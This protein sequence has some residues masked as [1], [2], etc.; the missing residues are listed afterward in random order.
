MTGTLIGLIDR[1]S[2]GL[3]ILLTL[4]IAVSQIYLFQDVSIFYAIFLLG[5]TI[6]SALEFVKKALERN[7]E[8]QSFWRPVRITL[9]LIILVLSILTTVYIVFNA[10]RLQASQPFI[11]DLEVV[12]GWLLIAVILVLVTVH[13]GM[14]FGG[15]ISLGIA[16]FVWGHLIPIDLL[17]HP[18]YDMQFIMSYLGMNAT[19][20]FF[21]FIGLM[22]SIHFLILFATVLFIAGVLSLFLELGKAAGRHVQGGAALP[23]IVGSTAVGSVMGQAVSNVAL[24]GQV[25]IPMMMKYGYKGSTA[26]AIES[27]ASTAGQLL[28][29]I[30]GLAAFMIASMLNLN[31]IDVALNAVY[32]A[33]LYVS[34]ITI[35]VLLVSRAQGIGILHEAVDWRLI[36]RILPT[37]VIPFAVVLALM[38]NYF[39][40]SFAGLIGIPL[41][42]ILAFLQ[43]SGL[44]PGFKKMSAELKEGLRLVTM[45]GLL[46]IA[47]GPF[48]QVIGI[49]QMASRLGTYFVIILPNNLP[50]LLALTMAI[51]LFAGMGLPTP[52]AYLLVALTVAPFLQELGLP[53]LSAHFFVFY[54][55]IFST[56]S[57]PVALACLTAC[58]ISKDTFFRTCVESMKIAGATFFIPFSFSFNPSL[59]EFPNISLKGLYFLVITLLVQ[60]LVT[61]GLIGFIRRPLTYSERGVAFMAAAA[62][63]IYL[64]YHAYAFLILFFALPLGACLWQFIKDGRGSNAG[65]EKV[66]V[67]IEVK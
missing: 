14:L 15:I 54:F 52:V 25:T 46:G 50:L 4:Y 27:V 19:D 53:A 2:F 41:V 33:V 17:A 64:F 43:G 6:I 51:C 3:M 13:W 5:T 45:L 7:K 56:I 29:P 61:I 21:S 9:S 60:V 40:P 30:L 23:A 66:A 37:F 38:L 10:G 42:L 67:N 35:A 8:I 47:I 44:R 31:Y 34:T 18:D 59:F 1:V 12:I 65:I 57:P 62:G 28:P 49:T 55:A 11:S 48:A 24:T 63:A 36:L 32:P 22:T 26:G 20:G 16:Y 39:T 58:K